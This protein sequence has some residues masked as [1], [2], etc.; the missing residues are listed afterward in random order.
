VGETTATQR[1]K[2]ARANV[3]QE[4]NLQSQSFEDALFATHARPIS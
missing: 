1:Q 2:L 4:Q 3:S